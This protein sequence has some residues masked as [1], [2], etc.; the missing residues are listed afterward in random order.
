MTG[1]VT[2]QGGTA[3]VGAHIVPEPIG[4]QPVTLPDITTIDTGVYNA[5]LHNGLYDLTARAE[6]YAAVTKRVFVPSEGEVRVDFV[7]G[8]AP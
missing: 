7:L 2:D 5:P 6:G 4:L 3:I 1:T 8:R